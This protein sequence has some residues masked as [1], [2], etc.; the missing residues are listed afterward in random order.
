[1]LQNRTCCQNCNKDAM[2][3]KLAKE[4]S[5]YHTNKHEL[6]S[7]KFETSCTNED[8]DSGH[9]NDPKLTSYGRQLLGSLKWQRM[10]DCANEFNEARA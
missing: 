9:Y 7:Q 1:M 5:N 2:P 8:W 4:Q 3:G 6:Y 10:K